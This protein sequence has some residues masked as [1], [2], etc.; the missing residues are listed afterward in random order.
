VPL[1]LATLAAVSAAS[2]VALLVGYYLVKEAFGLG[3]TRQ[4]APGCSPPDFDILVYYVP[5]I[6]WAPL[7]YAL[8]LH[9]Y[10]RRK[11]N[12]FGLLAP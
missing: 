7:L 3:S 9:Y 2:V 11:H 6:A 4:L 10:R 8:T 1:R 5:L 12:P